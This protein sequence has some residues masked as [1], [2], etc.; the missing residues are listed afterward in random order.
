ML[1]VDHFESFFRAA[2]KETYHHGEVRYAPALIVG[3]DPEAIPP[4]REILTQALGGRDPLTLPPL[5]REAITHAPSLL[6]AV[7]AQAPQ[8]IVTWRNLY[9]SLGEHLDVLTQLTDVPVLLLPHPRGEHALRPG[10]PL[11][12]RVMAIT[13]HLTGDDRL[14]QHAVAATAPGGTLFLAHV[15]DQRTFQ[16]Y[17]DTIS[18][19][20]SLNTDV[21]REEIAAQLLKEPR[22]FIASVKEVLRDKGVQIQLEAVVEMG[23]FLEEYRRLIDAHAIDLLVLNTKDDDQLAMHGLAYPLAVELRQI[24]MLLL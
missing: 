6:E 13:D 1:G 24:P 11:G 7:K 23:H 3:D 4:L 19:L 8:V 18:R 16:R 10:A 2:A 14:I 15:E 20:P 22:D 5:E 21:A 12:R 17:I 9:Y